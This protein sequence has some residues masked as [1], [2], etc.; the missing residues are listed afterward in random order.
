MDARQEKEEMKGL[1][2]K[3]A[4]LEREK[5]ALE[6]DLLL[7]KKSALFCSI[8]FRASLQAYERNQGEFS[9]FFI[10]TEFFSTAT[11]I[12][13]RFNANDRL[14]SDFLRYVSD[15]KN[16]DKFLSNFSNIV[17][18]GDFDTLLNELTASGFLGGTSAFPENFPFYSVPVTE[19]QEGVSGEGLLS[20]SEG[21]QAPVKGEELTPSQDTIK[22]PNKG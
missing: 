6:Q 17:N 8:F 22:A 10:N 4:E 12:A 15:F 5:A 14:R 9:R 3:I 1:R 20:L 11:T 13:E 7:S 19:F 21:L 16:S 18:Y 2:L